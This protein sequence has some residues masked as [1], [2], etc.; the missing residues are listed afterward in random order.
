MRNELSTH[1]PR[2]PRISHPARPH[3]HS[4][5]AGVA[6]SA[7]AAIGF[8]SK[9]VFAKYLYAHG[10]DFASVLALRSLLTLPVMWAWVLWHQGWD[11]LRRASSGAIAAAGLGG[12]VCYGF[13]AILDFY[14]LSMLDASVERVVLFSYPS[15]I[16]LAGVLLG[17]GLPS[18]R[19]LLAIVLTWTGIFFTVGGFDPSL[20]QRNATG[21]GY[22]L[23][24]AATYAAYF[25]LSERYVRR[26][27][28]QQFALYAM[29]A[30][31]A[32]ILL[33]FTLRGGWAG[34][35]VDI[36]AALPLAGLVLL[37]TALPLFLASEGVRRIGAQRSALV[38]TIGPVATMVLAALL[39]GERLHALQLAGSALIIIGI[40]VLELRRPEAAKDLA[41]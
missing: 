8:A 38:A 40:L 41:A 14:A 11:S 9:G 22:V 3:R 37:A 26:I 27:G 23:I 31:G 33:L 39:L 12:T 17:R 29:T 32:V 13:G 35:H 34:L 28:S 24:C 25:L 18:G 36:H 7:G 20:L 15:M 16:V 19:V 21:A 30:A 2:L 10:L 5:W 4:G 6:C 1:C